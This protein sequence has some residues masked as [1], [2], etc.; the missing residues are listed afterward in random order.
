VLES[1]HGRLR[2]GF[3]I[4]RARL[5]DGSLDVDGLHT[6]TLAVNVGR[7]FQLDGRVEGRDASGA[8]APAR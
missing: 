6:H 3:E 8:M 2:P 5:P 4:M 1:S 7:D